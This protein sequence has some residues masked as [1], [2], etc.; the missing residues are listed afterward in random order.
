VLNERKFAKMK[1]VPSFQ[2]PGGPAS[3]SNRRGA[4]TN[5]KSPADHTA[6]QGGKTGDNAAHG[7]S[8]ATSGDTHHSASPETP[9]APVVEDH[10]P[11]PARGSPAKPAVRIS[12]VLR[13]ASDVVGS[14][15]RTAAVS[16]SATLRQAI[17]S[18]LGYSQGTG[19]SAAPVDFARIT[20]RYPLP[21][22][23]LTI[24]DHILDRYVHFRFLPFIWAGDYASL[25]ICSDLGALLNGDT[26]GDSI[27]L[28]YDDRSAVKQDKQSGT[29]SE[30]SALSRCD[31]YTRQRFYV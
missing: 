11:S 20:I 25:R 13:A 26:H 27:S 14:R 30:E 15:P 10:T 22:R 23:T 28:H 6:P 3:K 24:E 4:T 21:R 29:L 18:L 31:S 8:V 16:R 7:P 19:S 17:D 9:R 2:L 5:T 12:V 1:T